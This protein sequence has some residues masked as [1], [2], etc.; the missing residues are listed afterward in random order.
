MI[1]KQARYLKVDDWVLG[2]EKRGVQYYGR[3]AHVEKISEDQMGF[4]VEF[5]TGEVKSGS[6]ADQMV[7]T[8]TRSEMKALNCPVWPRVGYVKGRRELILVN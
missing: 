3:I 6:H 7:N 4:L 2:P 8:W 5:A 1:P